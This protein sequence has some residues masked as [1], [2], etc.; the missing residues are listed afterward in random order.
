MRLKYLNIQKRYSHSIKLEENE[1]F[2]ESKITEEF[3]INL[4]ESIEKKDLWKESDNNYAYTILIYYLD[5]VHFQ[6]IGYFDGNKMNTILNINKTIN[7]F[8]I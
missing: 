8:E 6:L 1:K 7:S 5:D 2:D 3:V 4:M